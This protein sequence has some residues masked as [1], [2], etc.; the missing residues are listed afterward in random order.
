[1]KVNIFVAEV[2]GN[3]GG[4]P[5]VL[6][7]PAATNAEMPKGFRDGHWTFLCTTDSGNELLGRSVQTLEGELTL[8]GYV[9]IS[10]P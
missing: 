1:M 7:L 10:S 8:N 6:V 4:P 2:D 3:I 5:E 9:I